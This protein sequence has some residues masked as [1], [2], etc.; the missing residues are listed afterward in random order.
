MF[1][2]G[3]IPF[4]GGV[5]FTFS[6]RKGIEERAGP[7]PCVFDGPLGRFSQQVR[8]LCED[9]FDRIEIGAVGRQ[10]ENARPGAH[11][12]SLVT[13]EI[14]EDDD[15]ARLE[16]R[17]V[18]SLRHRDPGPD[19]ATS[20]LQLA[21]VVGP[22]HA[23]PISHGR[24]AQRPELAVGL[25]DEHSSDRVRSVSLLPERKRQFA[26]PSLRRGPLV[27]LV[28]PCPG[29]QRST[30]RGLWRREARCLETPGP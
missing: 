11:G 14:V 4:V 5:V 7:P 10:E 3:I 1:L 25:R 26:K 13:A 17:T 16:R 30:R 15:I 12:A 27:K 28:S 2:Y 21:M 19:A 20:R 8:E 18:P 29:A 22:I 9:L 24:N 6:G 23:D